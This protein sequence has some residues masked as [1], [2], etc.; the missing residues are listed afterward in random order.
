LSSYITVV[1]CFVFFEN[2]AFIISRIFYLKGGYM[3]IKYAVIAK[4]ELLIGGLEGSSES[5]QVMI[6]NS[7]TNALI[8]SWSREGSYS[9]RTLI[10]GF[11]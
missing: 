1:G 3:D 5:L 9:T 10:E 11:Y 4:G 6:E 8:W 2:L 7:W